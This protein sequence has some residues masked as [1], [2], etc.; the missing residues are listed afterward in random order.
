V[1]GFIEL[2]RGDH[3]AALEYLEPSWEIRDRVRLLEPGQRLE[4]GDLVEALVAV[5][6]VDD[7][8]ERVRPFEELSV[9][10]DR[11]WALAI[12]ARCHGLILAARGDVAGAQASFDR[13]LVEHARTEDPYQHARTLL[14]LGVVQRRAKQRAAAR[15]ALDEALAIFDRLGASVWAEKTRDALRRIGGR[16]R[17]IDELTEGERRIASLVAEGRTNKEVAATL[18]VTEHTVEAALTRAY[19]KLEVRSRAELAA[20]LGRRSVGTDEGEL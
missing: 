7:A 17:S 6:R 20:Q 15:V 13:A 5:G 18:F 3:A 16:V 2:S 4:M 14:A 11:P 19:R 8:E 9:V 10:L 12:A 1:L